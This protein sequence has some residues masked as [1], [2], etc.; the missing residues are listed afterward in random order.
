VGASLPVLCLLL[1]TLAGAAHSGETFTASLLV[2]AFL[3]AIGMLSAQLGLWATLGYAI[4]DLVLNERSGAGPLRGAAL[5]VSY[6]LL[7][8]LTVYL[9]LLTG[10]ARLSARRVN[11]RGNPSTTLELLA[12]VATAGAGALLWSQALQALI[13]PGNDPAPLRDRWGVLVAVLVVMAALRVWGE[14]SARGGPVKAH[15]AEVR[16]A[17]GQRARSPSTA[18]PE[19]MRIGA[20]ALLL[21]LFV[22]GLIASLPQAVLALGFFAVLLRARMILTLRRPH[23]PQPVAARAGVLVRAGVAAVV[24]YTLTWLLLTAAGGPWPVLAGLCLTVGLVSL[25][26]VGPQSARGAEAWR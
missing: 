24:G 13:R 17:L 11:E 2:M 26:I 1:G 6:G 22:S 25:A 12:A 8:L 4:G 14:H 5:L 15:V 16:A 10:A 7:A 21:T 19:P 23:A 20:E 18:W 3:G 9:P